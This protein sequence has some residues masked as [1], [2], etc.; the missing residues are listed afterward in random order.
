MVPWPFRLKFGREMGTHPGRSVPMF[1]MGTPTPW[2]RGFAAGSGFAPGW[3]SEEGWGS[4][5]GCGFAAGL[6]TT[7]GLEFAAIVQNAPGEAGYP[8]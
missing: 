3:G 2:V 6:N 4:A 8:C 5:V 7:E 1:E